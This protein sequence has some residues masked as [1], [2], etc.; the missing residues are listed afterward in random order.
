MSD[1]V[2]NQV[3]VNQVVVNQVVVNKIEN[4]YDLPHG[5]LMGYPGRS[6]E[7]AIAEYEQK[8]GH[9]PLQA[10]T[11]ISQCGPLKGKPT[12]WLE[13]DWSKLAAIETDIFA[14]GKR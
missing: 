1:I 8:W 5:G 6:A 3:I 7:A 4:T 12:T 11:R 13:P 9:T 10:W 14:G 2:V